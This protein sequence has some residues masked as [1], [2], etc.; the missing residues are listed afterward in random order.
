MTN[1]FCCFFSNGGIL[2]KRYYK[3]HSDLLSSG[4]IWQQMQIHSCLPIRLV[5]SVSES[6]KLYCTFLC[7]RIQIPARLALKKTNTSLPRLWVSSE[8]ICGKFSTSH[9]ILS[10]P[11]L[12]FTSSWERTPDWT[13]R[14]SYFMDYNN[15]GY[16]STLTSFPSRLRVSC[17]DKM[18]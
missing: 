17:G 2:N 12:E 5:R 9:P 8:Q 10:T 6:S 13:L 18:N 1:Y 3:S 16:H 11:F 14:G 4:V 15:N 7:L